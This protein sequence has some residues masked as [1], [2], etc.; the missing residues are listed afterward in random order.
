MSLGSRKGMHK[1][2]KMMVQASFQNSANPGER[3]ADEAK[4]VVTACSQGLTEPGIWVC[5]LL[6]SSPPLTLD[7]CSFRTTNNLPTAE[8]QRREEE[9]DMLPICGTAETGK[10]PQGPSSTHR[11]DSAD[12]IL[13]SAMCQALGTSW[14]AYVLFYEA[15]PALGYLIPGVPWL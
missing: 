7:Q 6:A 9:R 11:L 8:K 14:T 3:K 5:N 2:P 4:E 13:S 15:S 10:P 1:P 12:I